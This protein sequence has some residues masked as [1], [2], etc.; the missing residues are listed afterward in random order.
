MVGTDQGTV[1]NLTTGKDSPEKET[2]A[3]LEQAGLFTHLIRESR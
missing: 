2:N 3:R 1:Q